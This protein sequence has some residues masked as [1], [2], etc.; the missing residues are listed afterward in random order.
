MEREEKERGKGREWSGSEGSVVGFMYLSA[1]KR[2][3]FNFVIEKV[4]CNITVHI[5]EKI[6]QFT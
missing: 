2:E 5:E 1:F 6:Y 4:I 3:L